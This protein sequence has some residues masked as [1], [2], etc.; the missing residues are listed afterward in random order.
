MPINIK[1]QATVLLVRELAERSGTSLTDAVHVALEH[2]LIDLYRAGKTNA[3]YSALFARA[4]SA[5]E[6]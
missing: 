3:E 4:D 5:N 1:R 6:V 2:A